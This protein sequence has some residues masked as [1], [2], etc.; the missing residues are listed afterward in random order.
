MNRIKLIL[1]GKTDKGWIT[2]GFKVYEKRLKHYTKLDIIYVSAKTSGAHEQLEAEGKE[3]LRK[4]AA[5]DYVILLDEQGKSMT[6]KD[7][8]KHLESV[9]LRGIGEVTFVIGGAYGFSP[10]VYQRANFKISLSPMTFT[11]QMVRVI[12]LEQLYRAFTILKGE[13]YHH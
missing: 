1:V 6:S 10:D 2:E 4:C 12:F 8:A 7:L 13:K 3:I 5:S 9:G 11:H